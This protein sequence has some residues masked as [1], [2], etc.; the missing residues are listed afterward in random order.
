M[1]N[2]L[3]FIFFFSL[4]ALI[5][6]IL[7]LAVFR[8]AALF[9]GS[10]FLR[11]RWQLEISGVMVVLT[12]S[13]NV[14][15]RY[16]YAWLAHS[17]YTAT[18]WYWGLMNIWL[19]VFLLGYFVYKIINRRLKWTK[20]RFGALLFGLSLV[21]YGLALLM[22]AWPQVKTVNVKLSNLPVAWDN[23]KIVQ[24]SDLH[25][26]AIN[27][28]VFLDRV[29]Q[30][31]NKQKPDMVVITGDLFDGVAANYPK[32]TE[33]LIGLQVPN[34]VFYISG[35]HER[36]AQMNN[37]PSLVPGNVKVLNNQ[38]TNIN[39]LS[40]IGVS[41][42][43]GQIRGHLADVL[44]ELAST[45]LPCRILLYHSPV[46][47]AVA[48]A[49]DVQLMLSGHTH[50]GQMW[51]YN[52]LSA[53]IFAGL[54]DGLTTQGDFNLYSNAGTGSW[55]PPARTVSFGEVTVIKLQQK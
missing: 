1:F 26:G 14:W 34:G 52:F 38:F 9:F 43:D 36:Y 17:V 47:I 21:W 25:L 55:G 54:D 50:R 8:L 15:C 33:A 22:A 16:S 41:Y 37:L 20:P 13:A 18:W 45:A 42:P 46:D 40:L 35:N 2:W 3:G 30:L 49:A 12:I 27:G 28:P 7:Q 51:P 48:K 10:Q 5:L 19:W 44:P 23:K 39:G 53:L 24:I 4:A 11:W 6:I 29:V 32:L 31:V